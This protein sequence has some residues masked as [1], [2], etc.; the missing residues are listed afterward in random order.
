MAL[1]TILIIVN[2]KV[3]GV[4]YRQTT[5]EIADQLGIKGSVKNKPD[6]TVEIIATGTKE[7]LNELID[8]CR[9]G[10]PRA[11]VSAV[12][13]TEIPLQQFTEFT[14]NRHK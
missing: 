2:G 12:D 7:Q 4:F 9:Q 10:P 6:G 3:Q 8:W 11:A 14:I 5:R 1:S 13:T